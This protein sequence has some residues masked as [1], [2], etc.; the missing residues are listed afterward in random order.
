[1]SLK[2]KSIN[3]VLDAYVNNIQKDYERFVEKNG[4]SNIYDDKQLKLLKSHETAI[5]IATSLKTQFENWY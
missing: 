1:M 5:K 2:A 3:C 4:P